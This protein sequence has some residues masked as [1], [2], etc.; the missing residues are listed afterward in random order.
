[1]QLKKAT[2]QYSNQ[3]NDL[4]SELIIAYPESFL[5]TEHDIYQNSLNIT[6]SQDIDIFIALENGKLMGMLEYHKGKYYK[7]RYT[8]AIEKFGILPSARNKGI[9]SQLLRYALSIIKEEYS[10]HRIEI[11]VN[12]ISKEAIEVYKKFG[13]KEEGRLKHVLFQNNKFEDVIIMALLN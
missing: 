5:L 6:F 7:R 3:I 13:F 11:Y 10:P 9:G 1:M 12:A 2:N 8:G 4:Y